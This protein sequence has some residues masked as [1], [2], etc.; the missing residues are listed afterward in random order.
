MPTTIAH[1]R[2]IFKIQKRLE[3]PNRK[4]TIYF[5]QNIRSISRDPNLKKLFNFVKIYDLNLVLFFQKIS[6]ISHDPVPLKSTNST[7]AT[8]TAST[9]EG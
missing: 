6:I 9:Y 2:R 4:K 8:S 3:E 1:R 7:E 5:C